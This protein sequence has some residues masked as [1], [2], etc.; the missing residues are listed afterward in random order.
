MP[1][2][3]T[4][5]ALTG[6]ELTTNAEYTVTDN[7]RPVQLEVTGIWDDGSQSR[8]NDYSI[9]VNG[10]D[11]GKLL[12]FMSE[13][14]GSFNLQATV[15][16]Q[17]SAAK[18]IVVR[19]ALNLETKTFTVIFHIVH[20]GEPVGTGYNIEASRIDYQ[21][22]LL[23]RTFERHNRYTPNSTMP[24]MKFELATIDPDGNNLSEPGINRLQ[25]PSPEASILFQDWMW[26]H[27]WDPEYY[28]N[29]WVG[30]TQNGY[31][32]GIYPSMSCDND[33]PLAG[34]GCADLDTP[35][36]LEGIALELDNLWQEN[37][38]FPHE[39]GHVFGLFHVFEG[40][41]CSHDVDH[42]ADTEQYS[43]AV[44]ESGADVV[45]RE[46]CSGRTFTS[47][48]IMDYWR[49]PNG[50]RDLSYDQVLRIRQ[51]IEKGNFRGQKSLAEGTP[52]KMERPGGG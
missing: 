5:P 13:E 33:E 2:T 17:E 30:D 46:A 27:Y 19:P 52:R 37:W 32:W 10:E 18:T 51:V 9:L 43:R 49:Q 21:M 47:Y 24:M 31:S 34:L 38:V 6:I 41:E 36:Q 15:E 42:C 45:T 14:A 50:Q 16:G 25:R 20:D 7:P 1:P 28:I 4:E 11:R 26:D 3:P 48:N 44:Y 22:D 23:A 35:Q 12:N 39:M 40:H 8:L 29:V